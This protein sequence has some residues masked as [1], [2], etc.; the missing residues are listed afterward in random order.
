MGLARPNIDA[1]H[2]RFPRSRAPLARYPYYGYN[3]RIDS[4]YA[5]EMSRINSTEHYMDWTGQWLARQRAAVCPAPLVAT[6]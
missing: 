6:H 4:I 1:T 5:K 2:A 3:G